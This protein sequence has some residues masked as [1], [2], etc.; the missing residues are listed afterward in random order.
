MKMKNYKRQL[1]RKGKGKKGNKKNKKNKKKR[2][3]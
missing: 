2:R 1:M 3:K